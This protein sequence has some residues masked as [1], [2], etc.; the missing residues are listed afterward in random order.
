MQKSKKIIGLI[1]SFICA[2]QQIGMAQ[3]M[4]ELNVANRLALMQSSFTVERF[5]PEHLRYFSYSPKD[6]N[7]TILLDK[8]DLV[9]GLSPKGT[10]P[11]QAIQD[12][13]KTLLKYFLIGVTLPDDNFWVNLR[14]DSPDNMI[15]N[16][17]AQTDLGRILLEADLQLKKDTAQLTSPQTPEGKAYWDKLY[18]KAG[19]IF[20]SSEITIPTL[21]RPWIV[22]GEIIVREDTQSAYIYKANLKVMLEEDYLKSSNQHSVVSSQGYEFN[23]TRLKALNIYSTQLVKE[24]ILPKLTKE[25]N[26]AQRYA[27]LRQVY[28]SLILSRW[29][30]TRFAGQAGTYP[31]LINKANLA[32]LTSTQSWS[33]DTYFQ[34]YQKSFKD[35]EYN[36]K[37]PAY[38]IYGQTIRSYFSG[39]FDLTSSSPMQNGLAN[40][41]ADMLAA[42]E[43][44]PNVAVFA[45]PADMPGAMRVMNMGTAQSVS[46]SP[47][48]ENSTDDK[49]VRPIRQRQQK[50]Q[51]VGRGA[52]VSQIET[53]QETE[54]GQLRRGSFPTKS[55][56]ASSAVKLAEAVAQKWNNEIKPLFLEIVNDPKGPAGALS[57][58]GEIE[59]FA[60]LVDDLYYKVYAKGSIQRGR[61]EAVRDILRN[62][63]GDLNMQQIDAMDEVIRNPNSEVGL[64][65]EDLLN[66]LR[67]IRPFVNVSESYSGPY[68]LKAL[69]EI[70]SENELKVF[71][72][73]FVT[74]LRTEN[75]SIGRDR[76]LETVKDA[77]NALG[78]IEARASSAV[79]T[80]QKAIARIDAFLAER[81]WYE[82]Q[83]SIVANILDGIFSAVDHDSIVKWL[84]I[85]IDTARC[86]DYASYEWEEGNVEVYSDLAYAAI[87]RGIFTD[88]DHDLIIRLLKWLSLDNHEELSN[89]ERI[90]SIAFKKRIIPMSEIKGYMY[91]LQEEALLFALQGLI[92]EFTV[93]RH[94]TSED[95]GYLLG[96]VSR[97]IAKL[98]RR[99][100]VYS[101]EPIITST[102]VVTRDTFKQEKSDEVQASVRIRARALIQIVAALFEGKIFLLNDVEVIGKNL[103][104]RGYNGV[105]QKILEECD[106]DVNEIASSS[107]APKAD[108]ERSRSSSSV[109]EASPFTSA[110]L[111]ALAKILTLQDSH[112]AGDDQVVYSLKDGYTLSLRRVGI[113]TEFTFSGPGKS[114]AI[115]TVIP[116]D[117]LRSGE[118][119]QMTV[120][121]LIL[122]LADTVAQK[123][124]DP[125]G[126][127][128][129]GVAAD[130]DRQVIDDTQPKLP[131][132][133]AIRYIKAKITPD[134]LRE[135]LQYSQE[136]RW[137]ASL[138]DVT[139]RRRNA[140]LRRFADSGDSLQI[141][142]TQLR[143]PFDSTKQASQDLLR[144]LE[145]FIKR[146]K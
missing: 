129:V 39:G 115:T 105:V 83:N 127:V 123:E 10:V 107:L 140:F 13:S 91:L 97:E 6:N 23:D 100:D 139:F 38:S 138:R 29:F 98:P 119:K 34:A 79:R 137:K 84:S 57:A 106:I 21:T 146:Y 103:A 55:E 56:K 4:V 17:L 3:G 63:S 99:V 68:T 22:P 85:I 20:G 33:K 26:N 90:T 111:R 64:I 31:A 16:A 40:G 145:S 19:E 130:S 1:L 45:G 142:I 18:K 101:L 66:Q 12:S 80:K 95:R 128:E 134:V 43:R 14:P 35:G 69:S 49:I 78:R 82:A 70:K 93:D 32:N 132:E 37:A 77:Q 48:K 2:F 11:E 53:V 50:P 5:R 61:L 102:A 110:R 47:L 36:I 117:L 60:R 118:L 141:L 114:D 7:F 109:V 27:A 15:T 62:L 73:G 96:L 75:F 59:A 30:K 24:L 42:L 131:R 25:I 9:K 76:A 92:M 113:S 46:A 67:K 120:E 136:G 143:P 125:A 52:T 58:R 54:K 81:N 87:D 133:A 41:K 124:G 28:Y 51:D 88:K 116:R 126:L 86:A 94:F 108:L 112:R 8:G 72:N 89:H 65:V 44:G 104:S 71:L 122:L 121:T 135:L 74:S 144:Q